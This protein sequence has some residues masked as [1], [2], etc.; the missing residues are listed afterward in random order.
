MNKELIDITSLNL[1]KP[2]YR[3]TLRPIL[4][5]VIMTTFGLSLVLAG[6]QNFGLNWG[7]ILFGTIILILVIIF[8]LKVKDRRIADLYEELLVI[9]DFEDQSKGFLLPFSDIETWEFKTDAVFKDTLVF[10]LKNGETYVLENYRGQ[11]VISMLHKK[12]PEKEVKNG[13][14]KI[15]KK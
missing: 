5:L 11:K 15:F 10:L 1:G 8:I 2:V 13:L 14:L 7:I 6:I 12:A 3:M 4:V 9:Y